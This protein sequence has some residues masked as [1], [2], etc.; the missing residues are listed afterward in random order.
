MALSAWSPLLTDLSG[1]GVSPQTADV[2]R[3]SG[4]YFGMSE[5]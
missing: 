1:V 3:D 4:G 5:L 2:L